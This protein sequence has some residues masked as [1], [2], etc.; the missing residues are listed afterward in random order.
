M[1][2]YLALAVAALSFQMLQAAPAGHVTTLSDLEIAQRF[3]PIVI[4]EITRDASGK[5]VASDKIDDVTYDVAQTNDFIYISYQVLKSWSQNLEVEKV[6]Q[7]GGGMMVSMMLGGAKTTNHP[8]DGED[9]FVVV[10]KAENNELKLVMFASNAHGKH[11]TYTV[12]ENIAP[13]ELDKLESFNQGLEKPNFIS[14][15]FVRP[16]IQKLQDFSR[17]APHIDQHPVI[18]STGA[19]HSLVAARFEL[20]AISDAMKNGTMTVA[21][22]S[23]V[24]T[25]AGVIPLASVPYKLIS[26]QSIVSTMTFSPELLK[27][28][29]GGKAD[30]SK[31]ISLSLNGQSVTSPKLPTHLDPIWYL[32]RYSPNTLKEIQEQLADPALSAEKREILERYLAVPEADF[33]WNHENRINPAAAFKATFPITAKDENGDYTRYELLKVKAAAYSEIK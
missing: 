24:A 28:N 3:S 1:H 21:T 23:S 31:E 22:E 6:I 18:V 25:P 20:S 4:N 8:V 11:L 7:D 26:A 27:N 14:G 17:T 13:A 5:P 33:S 19:S 32:K 10:K 9:I 12:K 29:V 2:K 15:F 16:S 30:A